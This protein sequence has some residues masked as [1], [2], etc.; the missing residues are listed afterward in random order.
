MTLL[1]CYWTVTGLSCYWAVT[2]LLLI[3]YWTVTELLLNRYWYWTELLLS[4]CWTVTELLLRCYW[5]SSGLKLTHTH[6]TYHR[7]LKVT[8]GPVP[9]RLWNWWKQ[10][11]QPSV[12]MSV[13]KDTPL[14]HNIHLLAWKPLDA[15]LDL[16]ALIMQ[17][18]HFCASSCFNTRNLTPLFAVIELLLNRY[19]YCYWIIIEL[20]LNCY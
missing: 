17:P 4:C 6:K 15:F 5:S 9:R 10:Y 1:S 3:C 20:L 7:K 14:S 8:Q 16:V 13:G 11:K 2:K 18:S 12:L 19:W